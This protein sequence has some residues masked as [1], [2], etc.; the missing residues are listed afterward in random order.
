MSGDYNTWVFLNCPFDEDYRE[1]QYA[2]I[3]TIYWCGFFPRSAMEED[4]AL[5]SRLA[6]IETIIEESRFGIHDLSRI[7]VNANSMPRFNMPFEA[8]IFFGAKKF[9]NDA[10]KKK[11]AL[12]LEKEKYSYQQFISDLNGIDTK[13]NNNNPITAIKIVRDWLKAASRRDTISGHIIIIDNYTVFRNEI[14]PIS[15]MKLGLDIRSLTFIDYCA[16][17]E[18]LLDLNII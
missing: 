6:K 10:Q 4:N 8:G 12:I 15:A 13:A 16:M 18:D 3:F 5:Y 2:I 14:L 9:G 7:E 1:M 11:V 17:V